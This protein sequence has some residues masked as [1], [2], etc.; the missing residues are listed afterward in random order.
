[1]VDGGKYFYS[2]HN[3]G[4]DTVKSPMGMF[5]EDRIEN[6]VA[7][8]DQKICEYYAIN[9][10]DEIPDGTTPEAPAPITQHPV[11]EAQI[12]SSYL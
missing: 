8:I 5:E 9:E 2:T 12:E 11:K 7:L 4:H 6:D 1:M 10:P 3:N